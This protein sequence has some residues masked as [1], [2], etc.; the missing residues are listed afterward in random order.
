MVAAM[1]LVLRPVTRADV[2]AWLRLLAVAEAVDST[3]EN[4]DAEDLLEELRDPATGP[5][6]RLGVFD[7]ARMVA[8]AGVRPRGVT[9]FL[10]IDAEG[11]VD[12]ELRGQGLGT[13]LVNWV[14]D[15]CTT[16]QRSEVAPVETRI[17]TLGFLSNEA[18]VRLLEDNGF[19]QVNWSAVMRLDLPTAAP[20]PVWPSG[21]TLH[22]YDRAWS[23]ATM[24]A[25]NAAF[26]EHAGFVPWSAEKWEQWVDGTKNARP[27]LSWVVVDDADPGT[28]A[29]YL[30][31]NEFEANAAARGKREAYL[32]KL[33]VLR[34]YRGRGLASALLAQAS[35]EY[36]AHGYDEASLDVDTNNTTGAFGLYE[37]AGY[38]VDNRT[39]TFERIIASPA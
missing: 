27:E 29:A 22:T 23:Q 6:D 24:D 33:G 12:P 31:T 5:D 32:A 15:R 37:R 17:S 10:R 7:G 21:M 28:V 8:F 11:V 30:I 20:P 34:E 19:R 35:R 2:P 14:V 25:H 1:S 38:R 26:A 16:L 18:Q 4:Y 13:T 9:T 39:A 36:A 3:G